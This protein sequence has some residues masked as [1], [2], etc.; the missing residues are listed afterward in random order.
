MQQYRAGLQY[1][2]GAVHGVAAVYHYAQYGSITCT[3]QYT[4]G[5]QYMMAVVDTGLQYVMAAVHGM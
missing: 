1:M 2:H 5:L 3:Q 4:A